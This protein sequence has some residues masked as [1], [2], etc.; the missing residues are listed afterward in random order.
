MAY[1]VFIVSTLSPTYFVS[2]ICHRQRCGRITVCAWCC[3]FRILLICSAA[4]KPL[5]YRDND[6]P[7]LGQSHDMLWNVLRNK[8]D[9]YSSSLNSIKLPWI[10]FDLW[11]PQFQNKQK[12]NL[13]DPCEKR[14]R[15]KFNW[16]SVVL[17]ASTDEIAPC[18][19]NSETDRSS[20]WGLI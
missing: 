17:G 1:W 5:L 14:S 11:K 2:N 16:T 7:W 20:I 13:R 19:A 15:N 4:I 8:N 10:T 6:K 12:M 3:L 18:F 9:Y